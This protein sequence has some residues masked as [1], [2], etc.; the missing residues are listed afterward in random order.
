MEGES[1][2]TSI[3]LPPI[4][5]DLIKITGNEN[6]NDLTGGDEAELIE[7]LGG[8]DTLD[9]GLGND[10]MKGGT[11]NDTY[12][13]DNPN[14]VIIELPGEG[15]DEVFT[16]PNFIGNEFTLPSNVENLNMELSVDPTLGYLNATIGRGNELDN[17]IVGNT[18]NNSLYGYRGDDTIDGGLGGD[19]M[20]GGTGN[21]VYKVDNFLDNPIEYANKGTDTVEVSMFSG[22]FILSDHVENIILKE[23]FTGITTA[24]S[25]GNDIR[26]NSSG[27]EIFALDGADTVY[28]NEGDDILHGG[29]NNDLLVGGDDD[30]F[31][32][33][34]NGEDRLVGVGT[35]LL[36]GSVAS[37]APIGSTLVAVI[38][39]G[40]E[41]RDILDGG[42]DRETDVF[43]LGRSG[44]NWY[45]DSSGYAVV[46]NWNG[47][48]DRIE[49]PGTI[50]N[51]TFDERLMS[52]IGNPA[53][54]DTLIWKDGDVVAFL[55][56]TTDFDPSIDIDFV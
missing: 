13:V 24:N 29:G 11:G 22:D 35:G 43:V 19:L 30:D 41:E 1:K 50:D 36:N 33:G 15:I 6:D 56:D 14:D 48:E 38:P 27:N 55:E 39:G 51:Y 5:L 3:T 45:S 20:E 26:G 28:G 46:R 49:L 21:D 10:I 54:E 31:L 18:K 23:N 9:G 53:E 42:D 32:L 37:L 25:T 12:Y 7:G 47:G 52:Y 44:A 34:G 16:S 40:K 17:L 8:D 2:M 4:D